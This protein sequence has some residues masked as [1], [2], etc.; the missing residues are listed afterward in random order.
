MSGSGEPAKS[1]DSQIEES[2]TEQEEI[3]DSEK[4]TQ[5]GVGL[6][7]R[8]QAAA[9]EPQQEGGLLKKASSLTRE[10]KEEK[11]PSFT[12]ILTEKEAP[13]PLTEEPAEKET[14]EEKE[15]PIPSLEELSKEE[16]LEEKEAPETSGMAERK[17][18]AE[19][20]SESE[21]KT[22][23][24]LC[25]Q[26]VSDSDTMRLLELFDDVI[27]S[28]GY[29][30]FF[31]EI[32]GVCKKLARG[33]S[34]ILYLGSGAKYSVEYF[35]PESSEVRKCAKKTFRIQSKLIDVLKASPRGIR[36]SSLKDDAVKK[37]TASF[38]KVEPW[39]IIPLGSGERQSGFFLVGNQPKRPRI[40]TDG[41]VMLA[42]LTAKIV[43]RYTDEKNH[44]RELG[45]LEKENASLEKLLIL[46]SLLD[47][48]RGGIKEAFKLLCESLGIE[49]AAL[50]TGWSD[51]GKMKVI[52]SIG[53]SEKILR[54]YTL[55]KS[56][57]EIK[58]VVESGEPALLK[59]T[60]KRLARISKQKQ[61][62]LKTFILVPLRFGESVEGILTVHRM[63]KAGKK[64]P[65]EVKAS[66][67][68]GAKNL[69]P[70]ILQQE[71][72]GAQPFNLIEDFVNK[73]I[74][75]ARKKRGALHFLLFVLDTSKNM[76]A[77]E[78]GKV[79]F[80]L[81]QKIH[82]LIKKEGDADG[83]LLKRVDLKKLLFVMN[84]TTDVEADEFIKKIR[85]EFGKILTRKKREGQFMLTSLICRYPQDTRDPHE[86]LEWIY[87]GKGF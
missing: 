55:S 49:T 30:S 15:T 28:E 24:D 42:Y 21:I 65:K 9:E 81:V 5:N 36:S 71:N 3:E 67:A 26:A 32:S 84:D 62:Q 4:Q 66:L 41:L 40:H 43:D 12:G 34:V 23:G 16:I 1:A 73:C 53:L 31:R 20:V 74:E 72:A 39:M 22:F 59:D 78:N 58:K 68:Y 87:E 60:E 51:R 35:D 76:K 82:E 11:A 18:Q 86:I 80:D 85:H 7:R 13:V 38:E 56:D 14:H 6:L 52:E 2:S 77:E 61:E 19:P 54:S 45:R 27:R 8:A 64:L 17:E 33:K 37:E 10:P 69:V 75:L 50:L 25:E 46:S 79:Y 83:M 29:N 63:K 48:V 57:R 47:A 44:T 70:F